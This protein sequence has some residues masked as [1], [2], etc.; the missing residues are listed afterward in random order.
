MKS[1]G[2]GEMCIR[3]R[4]CRGG[5]ANEG[6]QDCFPSELCGTETKGGVVPVSYTHL[7]GTEATLI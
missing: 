5:R 1:T 7:P 4:G 3:D 2:C 6:E